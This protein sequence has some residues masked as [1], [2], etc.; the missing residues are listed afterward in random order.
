MKQRAIGVG[1]CVALIILS[2]IPAV[3]AN[4]IQIENAKPGA[5][6]WKLTSPG[7]MSGIIEG[8]ASLTSVNR[9]GQIR[10]FVKTAE[11]TYTMDI[12]RL[13]YYQG[14]GARRMMATI[15]RNAT[16]QPACPMDATTGLIECNWFDPYVDPIR[17]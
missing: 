14:L 9:G 11:P 4:A 15:N 7:N 13:G 3:A 16:S 17:W 2:A 1:V 6:D 8:Y 10:L 5:A 12:Y